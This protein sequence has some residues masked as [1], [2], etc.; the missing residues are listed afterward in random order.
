MSFLKDTLSIFKKRELSFLECHKESR[1]RLYFL[2][3]KDSD[4]S[5]KAGQHG[6]FNSIII[7]RKI[8]NPTRPFTLAAAPSENIVR[9][10]IKIDEKSK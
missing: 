4:L 6:L 8:K 1:K 7:H 10:T 3:E 9:I 2:F 5:W